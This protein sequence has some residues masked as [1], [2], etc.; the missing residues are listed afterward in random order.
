[1]DFEQVD[2]A[3]R[4]LDLDL[5]DREGRRC[6]KVDDLEFSGR[7][8]RHRP[9]SPT[10]AIHPAPA[11]PRRPRIWRRQHQDLLEDRR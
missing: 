1:M 10:S 9:G 3:Y 5:V 4:L 11:A 7:R 6:G 8:D 2:L